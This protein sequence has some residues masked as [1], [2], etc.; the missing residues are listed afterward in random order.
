MALGSRC[1]VA[2]CCRDVFVEGLYASEAQGLVV[3]LL[4]VVAASCQGNSQRDE[5]PGKRIAR[6]RRGL[7]RLL[8][9]NEW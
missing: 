9:L 6:G 2:A 5:R 3:Q 7:Q 8:T 4:L 1:I